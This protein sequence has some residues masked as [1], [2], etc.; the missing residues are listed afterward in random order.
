M[1]RITIL[2]LLARCLLA[3][4]ASAAPAGIYLFAMDGKQAASDKVICEQ[5]ERLMKDATG[6]RFWHADGRSYLITEYKLRDVVY[7]ED[8]LDPENPDFSKC[9]AI[10]QKTAASYPAA[11]RY[12]NP[13]IER[14]QTLAA[15]LADQKETRGRMA[16]LAIGRKELLNPRF[17]GFGSGV[18][19]ISHADGSEKVSL[20]EIND[21]M[22][23][24]LKRIDPSAAAIR[25]VTI[26]GKRLWNPRNA[27]LSAGIVAIEHEAGTLELDLDLA[28]SED[29]EKARLLGPGVANIKSEK[30]SGK[31]FWNPSFGGVSG[32]KVTVLHE[33]GKTALEI[34]SLS[35]QDK[36]VISG[37]S[38]GGWSISDA[39]FYQPAD[40]GDS[41][42]ELVLSG[43]K[44]FKNA[45]LAGRKGEAVVVSSS[46]GSHEIHVRDLGN[47]PGMSTGDKRRLE[48]WI[49]EMIE[50]RITNAA[51]IQTKDVLSFT[52]S[53]GPV[54]VAGF[55]I[56]SLEADGVFARNLTGTRVL[57]RETVRTTTSVVVDHPVDKEKKIHRVTGSSVSDR[58]VVVPVR[59][60]LCF[61]GPRHKNARVG[62]IDGRSAYRNA[63]LRL[64]GTRI[65][66]SDFAP[67][68]EVNKYLAE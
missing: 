6:T 17:K 4:S 2:A 24:S 28:T 15:A 46:S 37:W 62:R 30:I 23:A 63:S 65:H 3:G 11:G 9:L 66:T 21:D 51:P 52:K 7:F 49:G 55:D 33:K 5:F 67:P 32:G 34:A 47:L 58:D 20:D 26:G 48:T 12:L 1:T 10:Y 35:F 38:D 60:D 18:M 16:K 44:L 50:E 36:A 22:L 45:G 25:I 29:I 39:G 8:T 68:K 27:V 14:M 56:E 42:G 19:F 57:G 41:Y 54:Q 59:E 64:I 40:T 31:K 13:R 43:G 53:P 61:I